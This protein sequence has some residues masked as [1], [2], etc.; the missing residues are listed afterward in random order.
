MNFDLI[1]ILWTL[2]GVACLCMSILVGLL[3][4]HAFRTIPKLAD[5]PLPPP[6][7]PL[8]KVSLIAPARNEERNIE[9]A[10]RSLLK[11][12]YPNLEITI[13]RKTPREKFSTAWQQPSRG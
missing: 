1:T 2:W 7:V 9:A 8:P 4:L 6:D 3:M 10:M 5:L 12:D 11:I 13:V